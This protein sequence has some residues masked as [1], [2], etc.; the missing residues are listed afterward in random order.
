LC[1]T[2]GCSHG[3]IE[4]K[5]LRYHLAIKPTENDCLK[6]FNTAEHVLKNRIIKTLEYFNSGNSHNKAHK[7]ARKFNPIILFIDLTPIPMKNI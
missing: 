3:K 1:P 6:N 2:L 7:T 5:I 4:E